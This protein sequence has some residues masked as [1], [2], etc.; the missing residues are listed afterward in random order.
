MADKV[1]SVQDR[2]KGVV[3]IKQMSPA[4]GHAGGANPPGA[5]PRCSTSASTSSSGLAA[6]PDVVHVPCT[7]SPDG[8]ARADPDA[9]VVLCHLATRSMSVARYLAERD[10]DDV[11]NLTGG[12]DAWSRDVGGVPRY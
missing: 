1:A 7:R 12:I 11:A 10:F 5:G 4:G 9:L 6:L 3:M 8:S 2:L